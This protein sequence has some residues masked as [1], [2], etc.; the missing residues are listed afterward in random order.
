MLKF[1]SSES[2]VKET[3]KDHLGTFIFNIMGPYC[4]GD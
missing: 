1:S 2:F 4:F 3:S